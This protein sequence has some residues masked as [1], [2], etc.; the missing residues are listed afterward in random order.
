MNSDEIV[1]EYGIE[2]AIE[3]IAVKITE[4]IKEYKETKDETKQKELAD[5][6]L[7]REQIY[8]NNKEIIKK[9]ILQ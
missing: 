8:S 2:L 1:N 5:L 3:K 4:K 9:Y 7:D 6:L